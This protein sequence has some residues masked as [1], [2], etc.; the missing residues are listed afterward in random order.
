MTEYSATARYDGK[1]WS[2]AFDNLPEGYGGA[3][4]GR[5]WAE[6]ERMAREAVALL[7]DE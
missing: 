7:L 1:W 5:T 3:T 6:A 2:V 4:Q